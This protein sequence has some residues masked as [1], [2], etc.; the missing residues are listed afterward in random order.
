[1]V[2]FFFFFNVKRTKLPIF[3]NLSSHVCFKTR[4]PFDEPSCV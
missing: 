4:L 3:S 2:L 1:M